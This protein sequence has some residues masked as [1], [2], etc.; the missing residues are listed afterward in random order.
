M[1][2]K[3]SVGRRDREQNE[4]GTDTDLGFFLQSFFFFKKEKQSVMKC[5]VSVSSTAV[6]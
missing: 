3:R 2:A 6:P 1:V 4:H 5:K